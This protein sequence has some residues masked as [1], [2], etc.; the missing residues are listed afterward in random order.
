[1]TFGEGIGEISF[2]M[3]KETLSGTNLILNLSLSSRNCSWTT[4]FLFKNVSAFFLAIYLEL[5]ELGSW[6]TLGFN[7]L[8]SRE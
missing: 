5:L 7:V 4:R 6:I 3:Y 2:C 1:M 8:F